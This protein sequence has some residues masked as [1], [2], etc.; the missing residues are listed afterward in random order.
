MSNF[1]IRGR[2]AIGGIAEGTALVSREPIQGWGGVD[3]KTGFIIETGH[4]FEGLSIKGSIMFLS[5][6]KGSTG[7]SCHFHAAKVNNVGPCAMVFSKIDSRTGVAAAVLNIPV[8]TD[9]EEDPFNLIETG[10]WVKVDG[11][12]GIIEVTTKIHII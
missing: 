7:W 1:I 3:E 10:D 5:G 11:N 8:V 9:L 6:G 12:N 2:G 4:P